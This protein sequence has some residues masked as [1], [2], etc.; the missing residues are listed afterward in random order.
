MSGFYKRIVIII[1]EENLIQRI[2]P[3]DSKNTSA[4]KEHERA[5]ILKKMRP[6]A[7]LAV[8]IIEET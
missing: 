4:E 6:K 2:R 8:S 1:W 3:L 7:I 5:I